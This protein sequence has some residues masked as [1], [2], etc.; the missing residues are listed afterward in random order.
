MISDRRIHTI[1]PCPK[2]GA[3]SVSPSLPPAPLRASVP[4]MGATGSPES[5]EFCLS[6]HAAAFALECW[7]LGRTRTSES[8]GSPA[9]GGRSPMM[10][11]ALAP[12]SLEGSLTRET[13]G[14]W[15]LGSSQALLSLRLLSLMRHQTQPTFFPRFSGLPSV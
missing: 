7:C 1:S 3:V 15:G 2:R 12:T 11:G 10:S 8:L 13:R 4:M 6:H 14:P 5:L 9:G